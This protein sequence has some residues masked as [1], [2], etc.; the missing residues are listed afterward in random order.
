[1]VVNFTT[2]PTIPTWPR[3][4]VPTLLGPCCGSK[5]NTLPQIIKLNSQRTIT[6][7]S[8]LNYWQS[9][10]HSNPVALSNLD[11]RARAAAILCRNCI[12]CTNKTL[13]NET[14]ALLNLNTTLSKVNGATVTSS[15]GT[16][17]VSVY[18]GHSGVVD[19]VET[20][21]AAM[22]IAYLVAGWTV[23]VLCQ[24]RE[25]IILLRETIH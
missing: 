18:M 22:F 17:T 3:I 7:F 5:L 16:A 12:K 15:P 14:F 24:C 20:D 19:I 2:H 1:M 9:C 25:S 8:P 6:F 23:G 21:V 11:L 13:Q 4:L 10:F